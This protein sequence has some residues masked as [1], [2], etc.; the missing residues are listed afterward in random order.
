MV[1]FPKSIWIINLFWYL[2]SGFSSHQEVSDQG[3]R[4]AVAQTVGFLLTPTL[5]FSPRITNAY[6]PDTDPLR[7]SLYLISRVQE[8]TCLQERYIKKKLPPIKKMKLT[9]R[10]VD[11]SYRLLDQ[12]NYV[13]KFISP[14]DIILAA[15]VGNEAAD[16]LQDAIDFVY[17]YNKDGDAMTNEQKDFLVTALTETREKLFDFVEYL[18][19]QEKVLAARKRVEEENKLNVDE[20]DPDLANDAG[21]YNPVEL[22][23][24]N[25][26]K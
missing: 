6:E 8:A 19:D 15:Q 13:S 14:N 12:I 17:S 2:V 7:E 21:I 10:L 16:S 18:P 23:W 9:L 5:T 22:P 24:K 1:S 11:R 26:V 4:L 3:R 25:R 20:F